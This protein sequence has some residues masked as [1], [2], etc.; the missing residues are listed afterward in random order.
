M[1]ISVTGDIDAESYSSYI[2]DENTIS[3]MLVLPDISHNYQKLKLNHNF[4]FLGEFELEGAVYCIS[5]PAS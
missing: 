3:Y 2:M 4:L 5:I 1:D